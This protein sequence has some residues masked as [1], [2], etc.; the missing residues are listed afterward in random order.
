MFGLDWLALLAIAVGSYVVVGW[1][2]TL[3]IASW[4]SRREYSIRLSELGPDIGYAERDKLRE[5]VKFSTAEKWAMATLW[6]LTW[7]QVG[8]QGL[9]LSVR[10]FPQ[11]V[12]TI[13]RA[14]TR[15]NQTLAR[16]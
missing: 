7:A 16:K 5:N 4:L 8:T 3:I 9:L 12:R 1:I 13:N 6:P 15:I 2:S 14:F 10:A 11:A